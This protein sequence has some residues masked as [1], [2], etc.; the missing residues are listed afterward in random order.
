MQLVDLKI[1]LKLE[2]DK[3]KKTIKY[4]DRTFGDYFELYNI[5]CKDYCIKRGTQT[6]QNLHDLIMSNIFKMYK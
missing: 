1:K 3:E 2:F 4:N 6:D 5:I